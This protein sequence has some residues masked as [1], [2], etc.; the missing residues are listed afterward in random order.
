MISYNSPLI[1]KNDIRE[2]TKVLK[3]KWIT[4]GKFINKFE[5]NLKL[6]FKSK[7]VVA[8]SSGT[9]A[10]H[11]A[12]ITLG[13]KKNDIILLSPITFLATANSVLYT[14]ASID[15]VD[16]NIK[17]YN[18]D[19]MLLE[20]KIKILKKN[21]KKIKAVIATD[22]AGQPCDWKKLKKLSI[23]YRFKLINDNCHCIGSKYYKDV[24]YACKYADIVVHSYHAVKNITTGEGGAILT[25]N[26]S[27]YK[28]IKMLRS[29]G[30]DKAKKYSKNPWFY[31][32]EHLGYNYRITDFQCALGIS[33]LKR[34]DK[35]I[36]E[37]RRIAKRYDLDFKNNDKLII[38]YLEKYSY[39][40]YHLYPLQIKFQNLK[41][42]KIHFFNYCKKNKINLQVHYIPLHYQPLIKKSMESSYTK[43]K[44]CEIF[45]ENVFSIP[46]Y[47]GLSIKDQKKI[48]D[49]INSYTIKYSN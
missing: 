21:K 19:L 4:Q 44:N 10:L 45:Y 48:I 27:Y 11:L 46:L 30:I 36:R 42:N 2:V 1:S 32:I 29:H 12:A 25:N 49:L 6:K 18:I 14:G 28:K 22:Y 7:Y 37:R 16:I 47:L 17:N 9:A 24:S 41:K 8:L 39:H 43:L 31:K 3:S 20:K 40:S 34:L 38:P 5:N 23:Q 33:Q 35:S 26:Y 13:W 15:F